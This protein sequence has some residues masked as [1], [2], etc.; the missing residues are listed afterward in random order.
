MSHF[1]IQF[2][3]WLEIGKNK[4]SEQQSPHFR[5]SALSYNVLYLIIHAFRFITAFLF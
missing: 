2:I 5:R 3:I 4:N 1:I